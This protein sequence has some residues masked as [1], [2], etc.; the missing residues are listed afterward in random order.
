MSKRR[1]LT[2]FDPDAVP[3]LAIL[4]PR[5]P[6]EAGAPRRAAPIASVAGEASARAALD[7]VAG[8]MEA[9]RAEGRLAQALPLDAVDADHLVRDRMTADGAEMDALAASIRSRGQQAPIEVVALGEGRYGLISGWRRLHALARLRAEAGGDGEGGGAR[10]ATVL[11]FVRAPATA[12]DAY[13]AMV[14]EN[15]LRADVSFYER[16]RLAAEAARLGVHA[17]VPAA[18]AALYAGASAPRRS[19]IASFVALHEELGTML[20][21]GPAIPE[22]L[23]LALAGALRAEGTGDGFGQRLRA[24][25]RAADAGDAGVERAVLERALRE[26]RRPPRGGTPAAKGEEVAPGLFLAAARG[27]AVVSGPALDADALAALRDW[28]A[29]RG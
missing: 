1:R 19:K 13:R 18:I 2:P 20:R 21:F 29:A 25:L 7:A 24:A 3:P 28:L 8:E 10:F 15:E 17:D 27:R 26:A 14:E 11:A 22:R 5:E 16:A 23:G 4:R 9:A 6:G 12:A